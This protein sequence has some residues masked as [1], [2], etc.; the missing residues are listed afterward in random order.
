M[1]VGDHPGKGLAAA[2]SSRVSVR[3]CRPIVDFWSGCQRS[4][5]IDALGGLSR[6]EIFRVPPSFWANTGPAADIKATNVP[7]ARATHLRILYFLPDTTPVVAPFAGAFA[8]FPVGRKAS[9]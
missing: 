6:W 5:W 4:S 9:R 8:W 2:E 3:A 1:T 7:A